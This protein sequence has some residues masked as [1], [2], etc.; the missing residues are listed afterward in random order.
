MQHILQKL[1]SMSSVTLIF[2]VCQNQ[3]STQCQP[4][5]RI[6]LRDGINLI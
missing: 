5:W 2:T 1:S 6:W 4:H 3:S